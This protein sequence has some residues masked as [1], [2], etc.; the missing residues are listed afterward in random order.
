MILSI[1]R[2]TL[3]I[4]GE[5]VKMKYKRL[6]L[7]LSGESLGGESGKGICGDSLA[8]Y[9]VIVRD[10]H[11]K[12]HEIGIVVGGGNFW[13]G[14]VSGDMDRMAAD[15]IGTIATVM[16]AI[17]M[18]DALTH[19]GVPVS[20]LSAV[21]MPTIAEA[22]DAKRAR[23]YLDEGRVVVFG[24][25]TGSPFFSTDSA[26]ALRAAEI[27]ADVILKSTLVDGV[28][29]RDPNEDE[30]AILLKE[31]SFDEVLEK[32]LRVIDQTA[33]ALCRDF[34]LRMIVFNGTDPNNIARVLEEEDLGT[35]VR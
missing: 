14:R 30:G 17:A 5:D 21:P 8:V 22:M 7:K 25:G 31:V 9:A 28:Y 35:M 34:H 20:L 29:D 32:K 1:H 24:G 27:K 16:N 13:R 2:V 15:Q 12:G 4:G 33:A 6:L 23:R 10:L 18:T 19:L 26:A 11:A 3:G